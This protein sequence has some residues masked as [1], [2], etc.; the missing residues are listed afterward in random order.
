MKSENPSVEQY[1]AKIPEK[2]SQGFRELRTT[3]LENLPAGFEETMNYGM[4]GYVVPLALFP[5]GYHAALGEPLPFINLAVHKEHI[6]FYHMGLYADKELLE[7]FTREFPRN[8]TLKLN[9]GKSCIRFRN[10]SKI[11]FRLL[12]E[13]VG[14]IT[15]EKWI[16]LYQKSRSRPE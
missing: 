12:G 2:Y 16:T 11:P 13:L 9:M 15:P 8:S 3:V 4:I 7:W 5:A 10:P 6:S 1:M 14:K